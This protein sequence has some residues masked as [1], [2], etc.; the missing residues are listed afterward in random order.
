[1]TMIGR[2]E[3]RQFANPEALARAAAERWLGSAAPFFRFV[4]LSGGRIARHFLAAAAE[5]AVAYPAATH[6]LRQTDFFWADE[7]CVP[8]D[9]PESNYCLAK[10]ALLDRM[11]LPAACIHRLRGELPPDQAVLHANEELLR[12][13]PWNAAGLPV[14]D[15]IF[16]GMGED[17]HVASLFPSGS[18]APSVLESP[19]SVAVGPKPPNPRITLT[20]PILAAAKEVW[21]LVS[22]NDKELP[23]RNS[24]EDKAQTPL[25][26]LLNLRSSTVI[27]VDRFILNGSRA[28]KVETS[29]K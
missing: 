4:A 7:R 18:S 20:Y 24:L 1:M 17:G 21:V 25:N 15:L 16:L 26:R 6:K 27:L 5:L 10:E 29:G 14:F 2:V 9:H 11:D 3:L 8:P 23:L 12:V 19:Y 13:V 22:G 28:D